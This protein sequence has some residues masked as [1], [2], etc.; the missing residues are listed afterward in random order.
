RDAWEA[1]T[2]AESPGHAI[3]GCSAPNFAGRLADFAHAM[4]R[5][6][7]PAAGF[8]G[9][10]GAAAEALVAAMIAHPDLVAGEDR[11]CTALMRAAQGRAAVK[12][13]AEGV[14]FAILPGRGL[15]VALKIVD[16]ATRA[17]DAA[18]AALLV[19]LGVVEPAAV[20]ATSHTQQT[21]RRGI[22]TGQI[23]PHA[24]FFQNGAAL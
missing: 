14:F 9:R 24:A 13:G 11:A 10:R 12:T 1:C 7:A 4:A 15:G 18:M 6:A 8:G 23:R 20:R 5:F 21:N 17:A 19:R 22:V 16:G 3:D 2:G